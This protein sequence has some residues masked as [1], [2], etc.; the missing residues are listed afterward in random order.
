MDY[1][2]GQDAPGLGA[3]R[4]EC[5]PPNPPVSFVRIECVC[6]GYSTVGK[7]HAAARQ[8]SAAGTA[9]VELPE[10]DTAVPVGWSGWFGAL[11]VRAR[12]SAL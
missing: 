11:G 4:R 12:S 7:V 2:L 6:A 10:T 3:T 5:P 1:R 9:S 8:R